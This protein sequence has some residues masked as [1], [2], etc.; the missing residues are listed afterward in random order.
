MDRIFQPF[1]PRQSQYLARIVI[2]Q[3]N[4]SNGFHGWHY[5]RNSE[6]R[7]HLKNK[8]QLLTEAGN[9]IF[10]NLWNGRRYRKKERDKYIWFSI[11]FDI[12]RFILILKCRSHITRGK[13]STLHQCWLQVLNLWQVT[14]YNYYLS[15]TNGNE[16]SN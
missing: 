3:T 7:Q 12:N 15:P 11:N 10:S 9:I 4:Q 5:I 1:I 6:C 2:R 8:I 16:L 13:S 14:T